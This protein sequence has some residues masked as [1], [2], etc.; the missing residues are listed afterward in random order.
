MP[1]YLYKIVAFWVQNESVSVVLK[2]V[3]LNTAHTVG[4]NSQRGENFW[5]EKIKW[6]REQ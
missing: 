3:A 5:W 2:I 1:L 4:H 6:K